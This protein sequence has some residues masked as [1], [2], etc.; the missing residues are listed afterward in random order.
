MQD[1]AERVC[2]TCQHVHGT[3]KESTPLFDTMVNPWESFWEQRKEYERGEKEGR[4][5]AVG[6]F[7]GVYIYE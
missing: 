6:G 2:D 5:Y 4:P 3:G 1:G 7:H